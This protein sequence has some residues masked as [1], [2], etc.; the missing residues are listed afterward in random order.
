MLLKQI[1]YEKLKIHFEDIMDVLWNLSGVCLVCLVCCPW[2]A[3]LITWVITGHMGLVS[4]DHMG[5]AAVVEVNSIFIAV[6]AVE[7]A[8]LFLFDRFQLFVVRCC[9]ILKII[10]SNS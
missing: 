8:V 5:L 3:W 6:C 4:L 2:C 9:K 1:L 10:V 7:V